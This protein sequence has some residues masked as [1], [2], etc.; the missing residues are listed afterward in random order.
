MV[1]HHDHGLP[2]IARLH[3]VQSAAELAATRGF[4]DEHDAAAPARPASERF[5]AAPDEFRV[6]PFVGEVVNHEPGVTVTIE[7]R[8]S[9]NEDL[10][11]A[12]HHFVHALEVKPL[13]ACFP[14]VP[15]TVS[16]EI[17]AETA[18]CLAP[19]YGL[20][21]FENVSASRWIALA[22]TDSLTLSVTGRVRSVDAV[23]EIHRID[24]AETEQ[25]EARPSISATVLFSSHYQ[26]DL[27]LQFGALAADAGRSLRA[28]SVYEERELFHGPRF[29]CLVGEMVV[30]EHGAQAELEVRAPADL[31]RSTRHPQ[32]LSDPALLD[33]VGQTMAVWTLQQGGVVF[34]IGLGKL[35]LYRATP[36]PG[37]RVPMRVE[38]TGASGKTLTANVEIEDGH[39]GVWLR[40]RDWRSWR[41]QWDRKLVAFRQWPT[42]HLLSDTLAL[43]AG[44]RGEHAPCQRM[45]RTRLAGFDL[46]L[47]ARHYLHVDEMPV[48]R[49]L[50]NAPGQ[51]QLQ[52]LLGR[53]AAKD[54][55]R[56]WAA[57]Q[58]GSDEMLH[59]ASFAVTNDARGKPEVRHWPR[60]RAPALSLAHSGDDAVAIA[61]GA[62]V[63]IDF[64]RI[65]PRDANFLKS[66]A[67]EGERALLAKLPGG[68][69]EEW[70]ARIWCA[71]EAFGKLLGT[72]VDSTPHHFE[73]AAVEAG[74][75]LHMRHRPSGR[76]AHV[77]TLR[78]GGFI[79]AVAR[80]EAPG[81]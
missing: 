44:A 53:V 3:E 16:L 40:V 50:A 80:D 56:A 79:V 33:T 49:S 23:R 43:P 7:R 25:G 4:E 31:F 77:M 28:A 11:L 20:I 35:E 70:V 26:L 8:L 66:M 71:K 76:E 60:E 81:A 5:R 54:A 15:M 46:G 75:Q 73:A 41:F 64:E 72:G 32:L 52:W 48:F 47:L 37:T 27:N 63:G 61:Q 34:P 29:Q 1:N 10:H 57:Q 17:M 62:A 30:G 51:R 67:S 19:G 24:V 39:G 58:D 42:R 12:D 18:A 9:L 13:S 6:L 59:P 55:A 22:D 45:T 36:E 21:G 14:V 38:V 74:G 78:D 2:I 68:S 65:V 69:G